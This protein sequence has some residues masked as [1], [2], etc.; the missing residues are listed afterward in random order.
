MHFSACHLTHPPGISSLSHMK[1][2]SITGLSCHKGLRT[3]QA[4]LP[5]MASILDVWQKE[6]QMVTLLKYVDDLLLCADDLPTTE[7]PSLNLLCYLADQG[8]AASKSKQQWCSKSVVFLSH[9]ISHGVRHITKDRVKA[10]QEIP[11][12]VAQK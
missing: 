7:K 4:N 5:D 3:H 1:G 10:I 2:S 6:H 11:Q 8:C 9:C 12:P